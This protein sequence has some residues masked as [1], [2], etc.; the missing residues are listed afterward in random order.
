[1]L[2]LIGLLL[3]IAYVILSRS[4]A[5]D[6]LAESLRKASPS[7]RSHRANVENPDLPD[8][9]SERRLEVFEDFI[10]G[11]DPKQDIEEE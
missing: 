3:V 2:P 5:L 11:L 8:G 4:G 7:I 6:D 1:M 10:E 9:D